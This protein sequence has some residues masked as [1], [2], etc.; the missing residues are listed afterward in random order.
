MTS[1]NRHQL[2]DDE[3]DQQRPERHH[4]RGRGRRGSYDYDDDYVVFEE[5][6]EGDEEDVVVNGDNVY[7]GDNSAEE[8]NN[9]VCDGGG[10]V[11]GDDDRRRRHHHHHHVDG[12]FLPTSISRSTNSNIIINSTT[13]QNNN[14]KSTSCFH[15]YSSTSSPRSR[16]NN[17]NKKNSKSS[18]TTRRLHVTIANMM[19]LLVVCIATTIV[20]S[21]KS[22]RRY[23]SFATTASTTS[24][25]LTTRL[26]NNTGVGSAVPSNEA[27]TTATP[28]LATAM[29][30]AV[31]GSNKDDHS[32]D[33]TCVSTEEELRQ[34]IHNT[35]HV[36]ITAPA[37]AA[38]TSLQA[39]ARLCNEHNVQGYNFNY[40][41][42]STDY[43]NRRYNYEK[44]LLNSYEIPNIMASHVFHL[45]EFQYLLKSFMNKQDILMIHSFRQETSRLM[46][47]IQ[48]IL[49]CYCDPFNTRSH[50]PKGLWMT[51]DSIGGMNGTT[52]SNSTT[53]DN[54]LLNECHVTETNVINKIIKPRLQEIHKG[55]M[56]KLLKCSTYELIE[57]YVP[58]NFL[59]MNYQSSGK[60]QQLL[61]EKYCPKI[62]QQEGGAVY[63]VPQTSTKHGRN[64]SLSTKTT[65]T[66]TTSSTSS[67]L[68]MMSNSNNI[69]NHR[70][71][72]SD[73]SSATSSSMVHANSAEAKKTQ[74]YVH[75]NGNGNGG[76][77]VVMVQDW[78]KTK[79]STLEWSLG[80]NSGAECLSKTR[81]ME[82]LLFDTCSS[83]TKKKNGENGGVSLDGFVKASGLVKALIGSS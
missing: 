42:M 7:E 74:V 66:T 31:D 17:N 41:S 26:T 36:F 56:K 18:F 57:E 77:K 59:F 44:L 70:R 21:S 76:K 19:I 47:A 61:A 25:S 1:K 64:I 83:S 68:T 69:T 39:F 38:G 10:G 58:T 6:E 72:L 3:H 50:M 80:I 62:L 23:L 43:L 35:K 45:E 34:L 11:D 24:T 14:N 75:I 33:D 51:K 46:S 8:N 73:G 30:A 71:M 2:I 55:S 63:E 16:N 12:R 20:G 53:T 5:E 9:G 52:L 32:N 13:I 54:D 65:T 37:K 78:L 27:G 29:T 48:H 49:N 15:H 60:L 40:S 79:S 4:R 22:M 81:Q 82:D 28:G 67:S